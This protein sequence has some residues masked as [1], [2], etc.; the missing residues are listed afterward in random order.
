MSLV[1]YVDS[2][3]RGT[4][5]QTLFSL[6]TFTFA[7]HLKGETKRVEEERKTNKKKKEFELQK[8]K[9]KQRAPDKKFEALKTKCKCKSM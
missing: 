8:E 1:V 2:Q 5:A 4:G 3:H 6:S 9:K 7:P